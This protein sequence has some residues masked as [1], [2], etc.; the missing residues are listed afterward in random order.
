[1]FS[2]MFRLQVGLRGDY[3]TF[4]VDDLLEG[5]PTGLPQAS[6]YAQQAILSPKV[7]VV[8]NPVSSFDVFANFGSGFHSNDARAIVQG[9]R[10]SDLLRTYT[11]QGLSDAAIEA[12][13]EQQHFDRAQASTGILPRAI[14]SELGVRHRIGH[15]AVLSAAAWLLDLDDE[16]VYVG[17]GGYT[18]L[19]G[20]SR[21]SGIDLEARLQLASSLAA[22]ADL[23]LSRGRLRDKPGGANHIPLAPRV[24]STGGLTMLHPG[25]FEGSLRYVHVGDRPANESNSVVAQGYTLVNLVASYTLG[26]IKLSIMLENILDV[27]WNEAQF[28]TESRLPGEESAVSELHF[29]PGNPRTIRLGMS[30][31]F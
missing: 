27:D 28:D 12:N 13:L 3:F 10:V 6:G 5:A 16:F 1:M 21:R 30:Y 31:L 2:S 25:G 26:R 8:F 24:T 18:E 22:D 19:S 14:G 9:R 29:T 4:N 7:N 20:R 15:T 17:D 23:N 11:R